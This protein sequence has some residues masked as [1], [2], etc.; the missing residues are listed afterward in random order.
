MILETLTPGKETVRP[1][2]VAPA[3]PPDQPAREARDKSTR[4]Q[5]AAH[6]ENGARNASTEKDQG[7]LAG[8]DLLRDVLEAVENHP[9][10]RNTG[11]EFSVHEETGRLRVTVTD[12][13]TERVIREIPSEKLLDL[14]G[15]MEEMVGILF[16]AKA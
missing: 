6:E 1:A 15:K 9:S 14:I 10:V 4:R 7:G 12:K 5:V 2:P 8:A 16:D 13:E 11:L 3:L